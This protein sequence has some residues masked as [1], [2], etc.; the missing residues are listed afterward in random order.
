M[1]INVRTKYLNHIC[2][3]KFVSKLKD[4]GTGFLLVAL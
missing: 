3:N 2:K 1:K 4:E